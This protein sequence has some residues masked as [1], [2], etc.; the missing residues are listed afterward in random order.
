[1]RGAVQAIGRGLAAAIAGTAISA[2]ALQPIGFTPQGEVAQVRQLVAKFDADG[3]QAIAE[4]QLLEVIASYLG[5]R[6]IN[7]PATDIPLPPLLRGW[8]AARR[9]RSLRSPW[10]WRFGR[11]AAGGW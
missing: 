3:L 11:P 9:S 6:V 10:R 4:D 1:M 7:L 2:Q 5:T 8:Q